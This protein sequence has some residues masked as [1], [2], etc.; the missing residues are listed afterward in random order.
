MK[1][2]SQL[3]PVYERMER[4]VNT[5]ERI[6]VELAKLQ[7]T[8]ALMKVQTIQTRKDIAQASKSRTLP[9]LKH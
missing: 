6:L 1:S 2:K 7:N 9:D 4:M 8:L 5:E 3:P